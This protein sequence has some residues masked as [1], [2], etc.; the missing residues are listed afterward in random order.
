MCRVR[1]ALFVNEWSIRE[2]LGSFAI[3]GK[4]EL[5]WV[6]GGLECRYG[7]AKGSRPTERGFDEFLGHASGNMDYYRH[8]SRDRHDM[9]ESTQSL[10][11]DGVYATTL[12]A[13][14]AIGRVLDLAQKH[15]DRVQGLVEERL[16]WIQSV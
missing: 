9:F 1:E 16:R 3:F 5:R 13:D 11:R 7:F 8:N 6:W 2:C 10:H 14:A 12:F 15:P 4:L